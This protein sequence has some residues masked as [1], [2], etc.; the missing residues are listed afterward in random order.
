MT[1][2]TNVTL[3]HLTTRYT[4]NAIDSPN[5][6]LNLTNCFT[7]RKTST[8]ALKTRIAQYMYRVLLWV[9]ECI[10][11]GFIEVKSNSWSALAGVEAG[12][13]IRLQ[14]HEMVVS[15]AC[16][17]QSYSAHIKHLNWLGFHWS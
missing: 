10:R 15:L 1:V 2:K 9:L 3:V 14:R 11:V 4:A 6:L 16:S 7:G 8:L 17:S 13:F 5:E 12:E